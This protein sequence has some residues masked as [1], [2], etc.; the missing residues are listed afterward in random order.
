MIN[1]EEKKQ[2]IW[3]RNLNLAFVYMVI[4]LFG[5]V[6]VFAM[7]NILNSKVQELNESTYGM[8]NQDR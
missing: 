4:F 8:M 3:H 1:V 2:S 6:V 5:L 7:T